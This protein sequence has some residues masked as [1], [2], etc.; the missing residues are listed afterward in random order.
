M[1][2]VNS[3]EA[4]GRAALWDSCLTPTSQLPPGLHPC[5]GIKGSLL[6]A[7]THLPA[8][9][10][11]LAG[12][13]F[14]LTG[15][16]TVLSS[17]KEIFNL[18]STSSYSY[19]GFL[20]QNQEALATWHRLLVNEFVPPSSHLSLHLKSWMLRW[21]LWSVISCTASKFLVLLEVWTPWPRTSNPPGLSPLQ[22][23][24]CPYLVGPHNT[25]SNI[26][27]AVG[28]EEELFPITR[29]HSSAGALQFYFSQP[30]FFKCW[31]LT[32]AGNRLPKFWAAWIFLGSIL[33]SK[34]SLFL[35]GS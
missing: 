15:K 30:S 2:L 3:W 19:C 31:V 22:A 13:L 23:A 4:A 35:T 10:R 17:H 18:S 33:S 14:I 8:R 21:C 26:P 12:M 16:N 9:L 1:L 24:P 7:E 6:L 5:I 29:K 20:C 34:V 25:M 32:S 11:P 27:E 28:A